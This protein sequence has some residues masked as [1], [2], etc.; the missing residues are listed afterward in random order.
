MDNKDRLIK[1]GKVLLIVLWLLLT[2]ATC[3]A[4]WNAGLGLFFNITALCT[5]VGNILAVYK[6]ARKLE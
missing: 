3:S 1:G 5:L 4:V 6:F 2:I